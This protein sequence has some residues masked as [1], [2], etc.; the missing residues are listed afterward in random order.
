MCIDQRWAD[1]SVD[2]WNE[3]LTWVFLGQR[4]SYYASMENGIL[5]YLQNHQK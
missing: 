3:N 2:E 4:R 1:C 5:K